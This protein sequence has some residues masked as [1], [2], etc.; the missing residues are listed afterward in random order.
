MIERGK[1]EDGVGD[2]TQVKEQTVMEWMKTGLR[3]QGP[4]QGTGVVGESAACATEESR[5]RG[6]GEDIK[7]E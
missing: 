1:L 4:S 6:L 7:P 5:G 2:G 3:R